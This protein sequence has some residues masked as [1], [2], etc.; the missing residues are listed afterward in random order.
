MGDS[1]A[2]ADAKRSR[3]RDS[4]AAV[5]QLLKHSGHSVKLIDLKDVSITF[6]S[7]GK[8]ITIA[9]FT[10]VEIDITVDTAPEE[11]LASLSPPSTL[12]PE[13]LDMP[14]T[15]NLYYEDIV[16]GE[17]DEVTKEADLIDAAT[18]GDTERVSE[19][20]RSGVSA[21]TDD[22]S[23]LQLAAANGHAETVKVLLKGGAEGNDREALIE[24]AKSGYAD[25]VALLVSYADPETRR[26][27]LRLASEESPQ[28]PGVFGA[29]RYTPENGHASTIKILRP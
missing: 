14:K 20:L 8:E 12:N 13:E 3:A 24:A 5:K 27:A 21:K 16:E 26:E 10:D 9:P 1:E 4:I 15:T 2:K 18:Y 6:R 25:V 28:T 29:R 17:P 7:W 19:L 22:N 11:A 23:P